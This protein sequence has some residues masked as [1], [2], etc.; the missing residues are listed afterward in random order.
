VALLAALLLA[1]LAKSGLYVD[2]IVDG[3]KLSANP[4]TVVLSSYYGFGR[5]VCGGTY[6]SFWYMSSTPPGIIMVFGYTTPPSTPRYIVIDDGVTCL[7]IKTFNNDRAFYVVDQTRKRIYLV[8]FDPTTASVTIAGEWSYSSRYEI[9]TGEMNIEIYALNSVYQLNAVLKMLGLADASAVGDSTWFYAENGKYIEVYNGRTRIYQSPDLTSSPY[10]TRYLVIMID[11]TWPLRWTH[12]VYT[13]MNSVKYNLTDK[14]LIYF[15]ATDFTQ[16]IYPPYAST[17]TVTVTQTVA[18]TA[19]VTQTVTPVYTLPPVTYT[20]TIQ[21]PSLPT[22]NPQPAVPLPPLAVALSAPPASYLV[23]AIAI[24][25]A[26]FG[27]FARLSMSMIVAGGIA[28]AAAV[29][30]PNS[31]ALATVGLGMVILGIWNKRRQEG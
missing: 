14:F 27:A 22:W 31:A 5:N 2:V 13:D 8:T 9:T 10:T 20:P 6:Y 15:L 25:A 16:R 1:T 23:L 17:Q 12:A 4:S 28:M 30:L 26:A 7:P 19:T 21:M 3:S 11:V 24:F 29:F 18:Q